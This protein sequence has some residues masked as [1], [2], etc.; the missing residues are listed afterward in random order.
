M[1]KRD[2][3][4]SWIYR[5]AKE[6]VSVFEQNGLPCCLIGSAAAELWC[7]KP[8]GR[9]YYRV[10][11]D[12][13]LVVMAANADAEDLKRLLAEHGSGFTLDN[14]W[15]P[16]K[17]YKIVKYNAE[18]PLVERSTEWKLDILVPG[19]LDIPLIPEA[20]FIQLSMRLPDATYTLPCMPLLPL[21]ILKLHGWS[22][23]RNDK[24]CKDVRKLL[25]LAEHSGVTWA[26]FRRLPAEFP[27]ST[28]RVY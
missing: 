21:L 17:T 11:D 24:Q 10:P 25:H 7:Y 12:I 26:S 18:P 14:A 16:T 15:D 2:T 22:N 5:I 27:A 4:L 13:D 1:S 23:I 9:D 3:E 28:C 19:D 6:A 8:F 20:R